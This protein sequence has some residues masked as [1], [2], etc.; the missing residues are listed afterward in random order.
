[1]HEHA[2]SLIKSRANVA[3][4]LVQE[5]EPLCARAKSVF[6]LLETKFRAHNFD[7]FVVSI[8]D[9]TSKLEEFSC[10]RVPQV[11]LFTHGK[12]R[13]KLIGILSEEE[14]TETLSHI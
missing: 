7:M 14:I 10:V 13:H 5:N 6:S 8:S 9:K 2:L 3:I 11:R 1:M 12:L 4:L